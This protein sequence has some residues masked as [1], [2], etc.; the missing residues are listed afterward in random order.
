MSPLIVSKLE[1]KSPPHHI[2]TVITQTFNSW[3]F[4]C[5][6]IRGVHSSVEVVGVSVGC[7]VLSDAEHL[8][9]SPVL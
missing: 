4:H 5:C 1:F 8:G 2:K 9:L 6:V 3:L 7:F